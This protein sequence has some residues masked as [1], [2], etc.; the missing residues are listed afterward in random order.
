[1][2]NKTFLY[3]ALGLILCGL[4][5][6]LAADT[7]VT[8]S[9][10]V[11]A[12]EP[13]NCCASSFCEGKMTAGAEWLYWKTTQDNMALGRLDTFAAAA[14][15]PDETAPDAVTNLVGAGITSVQQEPKY[16][17]TN[18]FR[19][20][21][22]YELP[23]DKWDTRVTYT[24]MPTNA[25]YSSIAIGPQT[26]AATPVL[27]DDYV[28]QSGFTRNNDLLPPD[29]IPN[30]G[31]AG[32]PLFA[33]TQAYSAKWN[34][35]FN[36]IDFDLG[37]TVAFSECFK[38]R[39]HIGFRAAWFDQNLKFKD[40]YSFKDDAVANATMNTTVTNAYSAKEKFTGY[41]VETGLFSEW[42]L[43]YGLTLVGHLGG[44]ILYSEFKVKAEQSSVQVINTIPAAAGTVSTFTGTFEFKDT[45]HT[46]TP[47]VDYF[48]G[49]KYSDTTCD[50]MYSAIIGW[51]EHIIFNANRLNTVAGNLSTQ[52]LTLGLQL[53][54]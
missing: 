31:A 43:G 3:N 18:G 23:A 25:H 24:Y 36:N 11:C 34:G 19:V 17:Y 30:Q 54:F 45:I 35:A 20:N 39:P 16:N 22:G 14:A 37:R 50:M 52:G 10:P 42:N 51:E 1:M 46:G 6:P 4:T 48:V 2:K 38:L 44:S 5:A 29:L 21:I 27:G 28:A 8:T 32:D 7:C 26:V 41:G 53:D 12:P 15:N 9:A 47:T 40:T 49:L 13:E 33:D